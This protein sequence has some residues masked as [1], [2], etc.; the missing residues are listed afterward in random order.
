MKNTKAIDFTEGNLP[1]NLFKMFIPLYIAYFCSA[2]YD[3]I[4]SFWIGSLMGEKALAAQAASVP[5]VMLFS[6]LMMGATNGITII[7]S[8]YLGAKDKEKI[9]STI[10]TSLISLFLIGLM[11]MVACLVGINGILMTGNISTEIFHTARTYLFLR[12]LS[13]PL[14]ELYMYFAAIVRSHGNSSVQMASVFISI[15]FIVILDPILILHIG[16]N[17]AA[18]ATLLSQAIS[19]LIMIIYIM[20]KR[21]FSFDFKAMSKETLKEIGKCSVPSA[22]QQ[23]IPT[24]SVA[25]I[26][27]LFSGFGIA[28]LAAYSVASRLEVILLYPSLAINMS[29]TTAVSTC[30]G[31]KQSRKVKEYLK[32]GMIFSGCLVLILTP[33]LI[34]FSTNLATLFGISL[35]ATAIVKKYLSIISIGYVFNCITNSIMGEMNG[36]GQQVKS[37][38]LMALYFIIIRFPVAKILSSTT[39]GVDGISTSILISFSVAIIVAIV[40]QYNVMDKKIHE[41]VQT[42]SMEAMN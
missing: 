7:L 22:I 38:I 9:N 11:L 15:I 35:G 8:K 6:T 17:G 24:I 36:L 13:F 25:F 40:Y 29:E 21:I 41:I 16:I 12:I 37:M 34:I 3:I 31:A 27:S 4:D 26:Q 5:S 23:S 28:A 1:N 39:M 14:I 32:Y 19:M 30:Y 2:L 42:E 18:I 20:Q 10:T 33:I